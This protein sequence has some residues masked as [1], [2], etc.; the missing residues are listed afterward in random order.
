[1]TIVVDGQAAY[2]F[3]ETD[4]MLEIQHVLERRSTAVWLEELLMAEIPG[5]AFKVVILPGRR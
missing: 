4:M 5:Y 3:L 2:P 1:M